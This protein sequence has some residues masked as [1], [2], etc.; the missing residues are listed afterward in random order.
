MA[1]NCLLL[2]GCGGSGGAQP[3]YLSRAKL[4][5]PATCSDCHPKHYQEWS[6]SMHA[7]A[8]DDPLFLAMN[9]RGQ[10]EAQLGAFCVNCHA[11]LA[12]REGATADGLNL[13]DVP[14]ALHGVTCF[15]CHA[16]DQVQG[17]HNDPLHLA[18]DGVM[19]G[20]FNDPVPNTAHA[21]GYSVF[22]DRDRLESAQLCGSCHDIV[23]GHGAH[24]ERTFEEWQGSVFEQPN[25]G[26]SCSQCHMDQS[27][28]LEPAA[29]APGVFSRRLHSHRFPGVD[30][31]LTP[32]P[33]ADAQRDAVQ[34][35]LD[36]TLQSALCVRGI[37]LGT[38]TLQVILDSVA[39][40]HSWPS[41][42]AQDRRA[43]IEVNAY[44][45]GVSVYQSGVVPA[46]GFVNDVQDPDIWILRDCMVDDQDQEVHTFWD[47]TGYESTQLPAQVTFDMTKIEYYQSHVLQTYPRATPTLPAAPDRVTMRVH[48]EPFGKDAFDDLLANSSDG[49]RQALSAIASNLPSFTV[50]PE[51]EWTADKAGNIFR[52][53]GLPIS[54]VTTNLNA[55][56]DKV[57]AVPRKKCKP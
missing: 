33:D 53:N 47:A 55:Q 34:K 19:R 30:V 46:G 54:C 24:I 13:A 20:E 12:V 23:N 39:A 35:F 37:G 28:T 9:E 49:A 31:A 41:G 16:A 1:T 27:A 8:S 10:R 45:N 14:Q 32:F 5:D 15:F 42:S 25:L 26:L 56:A 7:Y 48:I 44:A 52:D 57:P 36:T 21:S 40:G 38:T 17:T 51:L 18:T 4:L 11:P 3:V 29:N 2:A 50:G 6:G 22:H 43:W